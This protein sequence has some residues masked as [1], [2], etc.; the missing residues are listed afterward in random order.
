MPQFSTC[1][2]ERSAAREAG[3]VRR[4]ADP[5]PVAGYQEQLM[6]V[7]GGYTRDVDGVARQAATPRR[8]HAAPPGV[9]PEMRG[10]GEHRHD[11][12]EFPVNLIPLFVPM[13]AVLMA[14]L[15]YMILGAV[16]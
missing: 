6:L 7:N 8:A 2:G 1:G 14:I 5:N 3:A 9:N 10:G 13:L 15:V 12:E 11:P 4:V 16:L